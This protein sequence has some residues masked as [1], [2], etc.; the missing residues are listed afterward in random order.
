MTQIIPN[1]QA[2]PQVVS[3]S[4]V[5]IY[6]SDHTW[7]SNQIMH[8]VKVLHVGDYS[9]SAEETGGTNAELKITLQK[10]LGNGW[11]DQP[12]EVSG[13]TFTAGQDRR[14]RVLCKVPYYDGV[15]TGVLPKYR[16]LAECPTGEVTLHSAEGSDGVPSGQWKP[17]YEFE[18][19]APVVVLSILK[20]GTAVST[21]AAWTANN[22][23]I[24]LVPLIGNRIAWHSRSSKTSNWETETVV[25]E[26]DSLGD[27]TFGSLTKLIN[28]DSSSLSSNTYSV[29]PIGNGKFGRYRTNPRS[30]D[31]YDCGLSGLTP[32]LVAIAQGA[33]TN[34]SGA[35]FS[36]LCNESQIAFLSGENGSYPQIHN[37]VYQFAVNNITNTVGVESSSGFI[38]GA[39]DRRLYYSSGL[40]L[41]SCLAPSG[42]IFIGKT[43]IASGGSYELSIAHVNYSGVVNKTLCPD[44]DGW[45]IAVYCQPDGKFIFAYVT[46]GGLIR[47]RCGSLSGSTFSFGDSV[48]YRGG[49][50]G[51]GT[52][53][54]HEGDMSS[55]DSGWFTF[56]Y[57]DAKNDLQAVLALS[58]DGV[59]INCNDTTG[60]TYGAGSQVLSLI[61]SGFNDKFIIG[62]YGDTGSVDYPNN[63]QRYVAMVEI[64]D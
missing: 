22:T 36:I 42:F 50:S 55:N 63:S 25:A 27:F 54:G 2:I 31:I 28:D 38:W 13:L 1:T 6:G 5:V 3:S 24:Q 33:V 32:T 47:L 11:E 8:G 9:F 41:A 20:V 53:H 16:L 58:T 57:Q 18:G 56:A 12:S 7:Q 59:T 35:K 43:H 37:V 10:D 29:F 14:S 34:E 4:P 30:F 49:E 44:T 46:T 64:T 15:D 17:E 52:E 21:G 60:T 26:F 23:N 62:N 39:I 19:D 51:F 40:S 45:P 48:D 61:K